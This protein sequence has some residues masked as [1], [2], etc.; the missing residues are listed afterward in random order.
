V[1]RF[2]TNAASTAWLALRIAILLD[3]DDTLYGRHEDRS[4]EQDF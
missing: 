4:R 2:M 1:M 3:I